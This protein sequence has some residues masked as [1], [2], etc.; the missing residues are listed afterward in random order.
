MIKKRKN[1]GNKKGERGVK[2]TWIGEET[3]L[4]KRGREEEG[5]RERE[6][7]GNLE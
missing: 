1:E 5:K 4:R 6:E 3:G 2:G 7:R